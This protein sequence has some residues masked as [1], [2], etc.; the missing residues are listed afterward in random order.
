MTTENKPEES[1]TIASEQTP[2]S[3]MLI[4]SDKSVASKLMTMIF[5]ASFYHGEKKI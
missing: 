3:K 4:N 5:L 2:F 1:F